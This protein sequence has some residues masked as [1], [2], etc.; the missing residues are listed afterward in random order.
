[1]T[2]APPPA[3]LPAVAPPVPAPIPVPVRPPRAKQRQIH[4]GAAAS[5]LLGQAEKEAAVG[6]HVEAAA[7]MERALRIEPENPLLW[8]ELGRLRMAEG[9]AEPAEGLY[10]KALTLAEGDGVVQARA[11]GLLAESLRARG[12]NQEAAAAQAHISLASPN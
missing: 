10:R 4:V 1:V 2:I 11:W 9:K 5:A 3:P 6:E 7:T 12:R 8:M